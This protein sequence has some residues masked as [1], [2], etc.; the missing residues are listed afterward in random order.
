MIA[1]FFAII[2]FFLYVMILSMAFFI[3]FVVISTYYLG[4][5][6]LLLCGVKTDKPSM[7]N[8]WGKFIYKMKKF[9]NTLWY[10]KNGKKNESV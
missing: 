9:N 7:T 10:G 6:I 5:I 4:K 1:I 2:A 8:M 3:A